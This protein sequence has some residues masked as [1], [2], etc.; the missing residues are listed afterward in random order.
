MT[1]TISLIVDTNLFFECKFLKEIQWNELGYDE[2][3]LLIT[4]PVQ[5]EIDKHKKTRTGR[6]YKKALK[7]STLF[8][9]MV[10]NKKQEVI[11]DSQPRVTLDFARGIYPDESHKNHL[12]Y[13]K[14]DDAI[15]GC[16][17][18]L[19]KRN[20]QECFALLTHDTGPMLT[21]E[22]LKLGCIP[23]PDSWLLPEQQN[24]DTKEI[25]RLK[26]EIKH[27]QSQE[28]DIEIVLYDT[29][30]EP[31]KRLDFKRVIYTA[32]D[33][34]Q[35]DSLIEKIRKKYP[36]DT[37]FGSEKTTPKPS[38]FSPFSFMQGACRWEFIETSSEQ[39][40]EYQLAYEKWLEDC[41]KLLSSLHTTLNHQDYPC[42]VLTA[43]NKGN[44]PAIDT[45]IEF[46]I[47]GNIEFFDRQL[48]TNSPPTLPTLPKAPKGKW[49]SHKLSRGIE[50]MIR[51][52]GLT[53]SRDLTNNMMQNHASLLRNFTPPKRDPNGF[54]W[55]G[56]KPDLPLKHT[57]LTCDQWR[58]SS[59]DQIFKFGLN[60]TKEEEDIKG[61]FSCKIHAENLTA[62]AEEKLPI[63]ITSTSVSCEDKAIQLVERFTAD[64][65]FLKDILK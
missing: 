51:G 35:I 5:N 34:G 57:S 43:S 30:G 40:E 65:V 39:K 10:I 16:L 52:I 9:D 11:Q 7:Y 3:K 41:R 1:K 22:N 19:L 49:K 59:K 36:E 45:L 61:L 60:A 48:M 63:K 44:R 55:K 62:P 42:F 13:S 15:V 25:N 17:S 32:L 2:I 50:D 8:R 29:A 6:T 47:D 20:P 64:K 31:I 54:Y 23:I 26:G 37:D 27:L 18:E 21:A 4:Q 12:D 28:P 14:N 46:N 56:D 38:S 58:H 53:G 24:S 33:E